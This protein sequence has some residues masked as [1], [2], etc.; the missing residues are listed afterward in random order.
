MNTLTYPV[1]GITAALLIGA[2]A[3]A[4]AQDPPAK[5][6]ATV[7]LRWVESKKI[8]GVT[9]DKGFSAV[10]T[11]RTSCTRTRSRPWC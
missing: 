10:A 3:V 7:E 4:S 6:R 9:E 5:P 2:P 11:R 1:I 8:E